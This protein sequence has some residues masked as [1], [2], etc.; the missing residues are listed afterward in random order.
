MAD[1][2]KDI[3]LKD[4]IDPKHPLMEALR[5]TANGTYKHSQSV[6]Q[7]VEA[8]SLELGIDTDMM[9]TAAM[10]HDIGKINYSNAF[11]ENQNGVNIHDDITP[12]MSYHII[13]KHISDSIMIMIQID[14]M[15]REVIQWVSQHHGNTVLRYFAEK[16]GDINSDTFRYKCKPPQ[17]IESAVLM[18]CDSVE[19]TVRS[20]S[21][22]Q[23]LDSS[24]KVVQNTFY[25]LEMDGQLD[26]I[27]VGQIRKMR[28]VIISELESGSYRRELY[29]EDKQDD[30]KMEK[31]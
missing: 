3:S 11:T 6:A 18:I 12:E 27:T 10:Y 29:P 25:R 4:L 13:T 30:A 26:A 19:A 17:S 21:S 31:N 2:D 23:K 20:L 14:E 16:A 15:P 1:E 5:L 7:L 22:N 9:K 28:E 8:V 24:E